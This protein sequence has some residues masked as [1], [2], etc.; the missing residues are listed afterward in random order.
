MSKKSIVGVGFVLIGILLEH[1]LPVLSA[2]YI[3]QAFFIIGMAVILWNKSAFDFSDSSFI[4]SF[5]PH[6]SHKKEF[7]NMLYGALAILLCFALPVLLFGRSAASAFFMLLLL[8]VCYVLYNEAIKPYIVCIYD[9]PENK[10][11]W[12]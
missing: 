3:Q 12:K 10:R 2:Y 7:K 4:E 5:K 1:F 11:F 8:P 9:T 6:P